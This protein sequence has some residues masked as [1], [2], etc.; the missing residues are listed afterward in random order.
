M[1]GLPI[2]DSEE[3][4]PYQG[5]G[6]EKAFLYE[7]VAN[8]VSGMDVDKWDYL[9]RDNYLLNIGILAQKHSRNNVRSSLTNFHFRYQVQI[10]EV[11]SDMP[12]GIRSR[13]WE[14]ENNGFPRLRSE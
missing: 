5:R 7:I 3:E 12:I 6:E 9:L 10:Q 8:K 13:K 2:E 4:W 1:T 14:K 11:H